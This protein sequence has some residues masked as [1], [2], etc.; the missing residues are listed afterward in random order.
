[1]RGGGARG[2]V[3]FGTDAARNDG[4][5]DMGDSCLNG[6]LAR[7]KSTDATVRRTC[8]CRPSCAGRGTLLLL[9]PPPWPLVLPPLLLAL[10][11]GSRSVRGSAVAC[12]KASTCATCA[13]AL[14]D[15]GVIPATVAEL[16]LTSKRL[17]HQLSRENRSPNSHKR[18]RSPFPL[19]AG[20]GG[21]LAQHDLLPRAIRKGGLFSAA[22]H[23]VP[24]DRPRQ[25]FGCV[26]RRRPRQLT[27]QK[28]LVR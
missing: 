26:S 5:S 21:P 25:L 18:T 8:C 6:G 10:L 4:C 3:S 11:L 13:D 1:M 16:E 12:R 22:A 17:N 20:D 7:A 19:G 15:R 9:R 28:G 24:S 23:V 2:G 14:G 27:R